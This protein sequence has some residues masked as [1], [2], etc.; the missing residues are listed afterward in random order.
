MTNPVDPKVPTTADDGLEGLADDISDAADKIGNDSVDTA[1]EDTAVE[2]TAVED[3]GGDSTAADAENGAD[4]DTEIDESKASSESADDTDTEIEDDGGETT[5]EDE[6]TTAADDDAVSVDGVDDADV[7]EGTA[8]ADEA[9]TSDEQDAVDV[10]NTDDTPPVEEEFVDDGLD[11]NLTVEDPALEDPAFEDLVEDSAGAEL[12]A[13]D[14]ID[15]ELTD[16]EDTAPI[17]GDDNQLAAYDGADDPTPEKPTILEMRQVAGLTAGSVMGLHK[18][19]FQFRESDKEVGFALTVESP[20][21]V[22][23]SPGSATTMIDEI[24]VDEPTPLGRGVLNVGTACFTVRRLRSK[25]DNASRLAAVMAGRTPPKAISVP[26]FETDQ[27]AVEQ[28]SS[29]RFGSLF[30]RN[31]EEPESE[32]DA[33]SWQFLESIRDIRSMVAERHRNL[34]PSPEELKSRLDRLD[35]GLWDRSIEHPLFGRFA[36]AYSTI[37]WE[38][39]FDAPERIPTQLHR[40]IQEMSC[41]PWVPITANLLVGP[42]GIVGGRSAVLACARNAVLSLACLSAPSDIEFSIVTAET[43]VSDWDWTSALPNSLFPSG[44]DNY[45]V[46]VADG[47]THFDGA[48]LDAEA[49]KNNEMGLVVLADTV[50]DLPDYCGTV[51]Q[52]TPEG[53]CQVTNHLGEQIVGTPIGVAASFASM[54]GAA[55]RE[56]IGDGPD[57]EDDGEYEYD[58]RYGS[59]DQAETLA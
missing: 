42:L 19:S 36:V 48:G 4:G 6:P 47:M 14:L 54:T 28:Q 39:R 45:C 1:V 56:A 7:I 46:A 11:E 44:S 55:L 15:E 57:Y 13:Q 50:E 37:P 5:P 30:S 16:G 31:S 10:G 2:E 59:E 53:Q 20:D 25:P 33:Q 43:L 8:E 22:V 40:P 29:S 41:L 21:D 27:P 23:V 35:P 24:V 58:G 9:V 18:G 12:A 52:L 38:P 51:L 32:L 49:V 3:A 26:Q 34:H 17:D